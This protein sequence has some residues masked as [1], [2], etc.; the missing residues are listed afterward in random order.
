MRGVFG[1]AALIA[2]GALLWAIFKGKV[3]LPGSIAFAPA[4]GT[5]PGG[6]TSGGKRVLPQ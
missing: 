3:T 2:G 5:Q 4:N 6:G 1:L